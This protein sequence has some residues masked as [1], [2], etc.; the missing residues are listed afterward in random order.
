MI[1]AS[2]EK[3]VLNSLAS[4]ADPADQPAPML[5]IVIPTYCE[6]ENV[7]K[8][9]EELLHVLIPIGI[10]WE[11]IF[12]DDGSTDNTWKNVVALHG[13][14]ARVKGL[15]LSRNFG[16][17]Y[18]LFAG[19][20]NASGRMVIT[21]DGD[22]QHPPSLIP[23][24]LNEWNKGSKIVH[25][26]R[27]DHE[28]IS[29]LKKFTAWAFYRFFSFLGGVELS[30]GMADFRLLDRQVVNELLRLKE[31]NLF[32]RGLVHW[33]GYPAS[34]IS[35]Q[36]RERFSGRTKY[37]LKKMIKFALTGIT[38]FS[39]VPLRL[40]ILLGLITSLVAFGELAYALWAKFFTDTTVPGWTSAVAI[41][42]FLFGILF[43]LLGVI[44]E[45]IGKILDE[46]RQRPRYIIHENV[47]VSLPTNPSVGG[48]SAPFEKAIL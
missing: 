48:S 46:V 5:S 45:Y 30:Q 40:A 12:V 13:K 47:G 43:I 15:R 2:K 37:S 9:Y 24:L 7:P 14:D 29:N 27:I 20:S 23:Q 18:A 32:I 1:L 19:L 22:L 21:M 4:S 36:C 28:G 11:I 10:T 8:L 44:G 33:I 34:K 41:V 16:H 38:A 31:G 17:Q 6:E 25:T 3:P 35:F 39:I 26:V 42:S